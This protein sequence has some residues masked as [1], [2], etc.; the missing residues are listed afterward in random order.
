[1]RAEQRQDVDRAVEQGIGGRENPDGVRK[2]MPMK[3]KKPLKSGLGHS[4]KDDG[5]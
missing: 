5:L 2:G 3:C 1:M 4:G